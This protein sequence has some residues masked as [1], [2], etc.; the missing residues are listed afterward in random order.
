[1][2]HRLNNNSLVGVIKRESEEEKK[3]IGRKGRKRREGRQEGE[4]EG[5]KERKK[6]RTEK[7][8][9]MAF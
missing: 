8:E 7:K 2:G 4:K 3:I 5:D 9:N 6:K 1:M